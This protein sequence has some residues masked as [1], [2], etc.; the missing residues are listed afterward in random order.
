M[1][2]KETEIENLK[3]EVSA[4]KSENE[5]LKAT[6]EKL[7]A[8]KNYAWKVYADKSDEARELRMRLEASKKMIDAFFEVPKTI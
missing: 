5:S 6:A 4:L 1:S 8:D 2:E 7:E 3:Q